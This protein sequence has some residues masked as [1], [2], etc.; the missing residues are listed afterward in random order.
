MP[1]RLKVHKSLF[2]KTFAAGNTSG[3]YLILQ[4]GQ[5]SISYS[6]F[7][8]VSQKYIAFES[9][10]ISGT[11]PNNT[12]A[13][14][15]KALMEEK[16]WLK[17]SFSKVFL[18]ID[19]SYSTL[20]P[21]PLFDENKTMT[22][23]RFNHP[24][25]ESY[26]ALFNRLK[27]SNTVTVFGA[28]QTLTEFTQNVWPNIRFFHCASVII[29]SLLINFKNKADS[30]T[31]FLNVRDE[32]YDLVYFKDN[33][34]QFHNFFRYNTK[35]DFIYFLLTTI[36]ELHLNPEQVK[37]MLSGNIDKSHILYEMI[38]RYI[39]TIFFIERTDVFGY[40]YLFDELMS[41]KYYTLFNVQQCE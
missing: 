14:F 22:Y 7:N 25:N 23:L 4:T 8:P 15:L 37:L 34:L 2:D 12:E 20:I 1:S 9:F 10:F 38:Y 39:R 27:T 13:E 28:P 30:Q 19:N 6:V 16:V 36:E 3:Y 35:E 11:D 17:Q 33:K 31:L 32:G 40:S 21:P 5:Q 18:L 41:H 29:E 26:H 24:A